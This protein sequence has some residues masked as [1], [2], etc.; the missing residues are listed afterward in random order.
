[1]KCHKFLHTS[2]VFSFTVINETTKPAE[3]KMGNENERD[4]PFHTDNKN[5]G[6]YIFRY[7][8]PSGP[9]AGAYR[10]NDSLAFY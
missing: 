7:N 8:I 3:N 1:M 10:G 2:V 5:G 9:S 6:L 4:V